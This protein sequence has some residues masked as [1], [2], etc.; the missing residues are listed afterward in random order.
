MNLALVGTFVLVLGAMLVG[1]VLWLAAGGALQ[2]HDNP[3]L[4]IL[5]ESVSGLNVD[6][7][8]KFNGVQVGKVREIT[9]DPQNSERVHL[10]L[11]IDR[12][13]PI[14]RDTVAVLKTQ[15]L[16]GIAYVE[17]K[18]A[19]EETP[20][21]EVNPSSKYPQ[22]RTEPSLGARLET[23]LGDVLSKLDSTSSLVNEILGPDNRKA[24]KEMLVDIATVVHTVAAREQSIGEGIVSAA[25]ALDNSARAT[26]R[27]DEVLERIGKSAQALES[28]GTEVART[29]ARAT[30]QIDPVLRQVGDSA[31]ALARM[32]DEV[33]NSAAGAG[34]AVNEVGAEIKRF[35]S[36]TVPELER[37]LGE[38]GVLSASLRRLSEQ[39]ER[40][41]A[42]LLFGRT[43][44]PEGPGE[45]SVRR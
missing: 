24:F 30:S 8:V 6:A 35:S 12:E 23:V 4:A 32:G 22:I 17:L 43:P 29:S 5:E 26:A 18:K 27:L 10:V 2:R 28:M 14:G 21:L 38:L 1:V 31:Q 41:P 25:Q 19:S 7:P 15:G 42:G 11:A 33:A 34:I 16:T 3:Y 36:R 45:E 40:D 39:T 44:V 20:P 13:A 9:L 37:L